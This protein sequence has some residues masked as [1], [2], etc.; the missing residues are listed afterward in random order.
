MAHRIV[1]KRVGQEPVVETR[2][3]ISLEVMQEIVGGNIKLLGL[4]NGIDLWLNEEGKLIDLYPNVALG[5]EIIV[6]DIFFAGST[7]QGDTVGLT[8]TQ[9]ELAL[10]LF[11]DPARN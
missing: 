2:E 9:I 5:Q 6:G 4:P 7:P 10:A 11:Y 8:G 1:V 3:E